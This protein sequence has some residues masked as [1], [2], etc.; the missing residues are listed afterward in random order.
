MK[1]VIISIIVLV[2]AA[3]AAYYLVFNKNTTN[4]YTPSTTN[5]MEMNNTS[6]TEPSTNVTPTTQVQAPANTPS[7]TSVTVNI[8]NFSFS[9]STLNVKTG[10]KVTWVNNDGVSHTVTSDSGNILNSGTLAS[11]ASFSFTFTNP[12]TVKYHCSIHPMMQ[13][14]VVVT[15]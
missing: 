11:G 14:S 8:K 1:K 3:I 12:G 5:N 7:P 4:Y 9:P 13:A 15:N 6:N 10:T 2:I